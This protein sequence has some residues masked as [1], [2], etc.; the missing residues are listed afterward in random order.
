VTANAL[1][2]HFVDGFVPRPKAGAADA[3][4]AA[5]V[6]YDDHCGFCSENARK[7]M[8]YQRAGALEWLGNS[9]PRAQAMLQER[10]IL[11]KEEETLIVF[12]GERSFF[13]S[14]AVVRCAQGLRWPW[15]MYAGLRFL[16]KAMRDR[17]YRRIA[18]DRDRHGC[19]L[20]V[21]TTPGSSG[22]PGKP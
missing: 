12:D 13:E 18:E 2:G 8:R 3:S 7:G 1:R 10:G 16:P 11:G 4:P 22:N 6:L 15:R 14:D 19:H 17:F 20:P 9:T 21:P 5:I